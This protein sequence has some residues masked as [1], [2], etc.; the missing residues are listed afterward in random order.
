MNLL[1]RIYA[2][3]DMKD[4]KINVAFLGSVNWDLDCDFY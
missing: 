1:F 2:H 4:S 3:S